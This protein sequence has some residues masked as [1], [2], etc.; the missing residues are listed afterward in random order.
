MF[1]AHA[2][3][4]TLNNKDDPSGLDCFR[5]EQILTAYFHFR[6]VILCL[7][8]MSR[9]RPGQVGIVFL[10]IVK[11][12]DHAWSVVLLAVRMLRMPPMRIEPDVEAVKRFVCKAAAV[13]VFQ[14][15]L[16]FPPSFLTCFEIQ[17]LVRNFD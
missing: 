4:L 17:P 3:D 15:F 13:H 11:R 1:Y 16:G 2:V 7:R 10:R 5:I 6:T 14:A 8:D 12:N 9:K